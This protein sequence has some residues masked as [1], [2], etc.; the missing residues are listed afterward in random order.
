MNKIKDNLKD[1]HVC[2][3]G[4]GREGQST[5]RWIWKYYFNDIKSLTIADQNPTSLYGEELEKCNCDLKYGYDYLS[6]IDN[7][8]IIIKSPGI[9]LSKTEEYIPEEKITSQSDIFLQ[10]FGDQCVGVTGTKGKSTTSTLIYSMLL[11]AGKKALLLGNIGEPPLDFWEKIEDETT[12][13][14]ELSSHQLEHIEKGPGIALLL[15]LFQEHLDHYV[16]FR[17]YQ[18]AKFNIALKQNDFATLITHYDDKRIQRLIDETEIHRELLYFSLQKHN[19]DGMYLQGDNIIYSRKEKEVIFA[20]YKKLE[21]LKGKHNLL[22]V[23]AAALAALQLGCETEV[24]QE[25]VYEFKGLQHRMEYVGT[26]QGISYYNDAIATIPEATIAAVEALGNVGTL[27]LGG[28]DR[29]IDYSDLAEFL[30]YAELNNIVF[31]GP[32]GERVLELMQ[33]SSNEISPKLFQAD[34][35]N[36]AVDYARKNTATGK[37]CLLSPAASSYDKFRNFAEKGDAFRRLVSE[38]QDEG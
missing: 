30:R 10:E 15:N 9:N 25:A 31:M 23:M 11:A 34:N 7:Y 18:L 35:L 32:A 19:H 28:F 36:I 24:L 16:D 27:I 4:Y 17:H 8:D 1:K 5:L 33:N 14:F 2:V 12:I 22:N 37:I 26:K 29:G 13:V 6:G 20:D 38:I 3:L 21:F